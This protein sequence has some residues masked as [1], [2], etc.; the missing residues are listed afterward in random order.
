[1]TLIDLGD[2]Y[3]RKFVYSDIKGLYETMQDVNTARHVSNR[4]QWSYK[5]VESFIKWNIEHEDDYYYAIVRKSDNAFIGYV[6][7]KIYNYKDDNILT[8]KNVLTIVIKEKK[9]GYGKRVVNAYITYCNDNNI[10]LYASV[11]EDNTP[12]N[13]L[14]ISLG[15]HPQAKLRVDGIT[16]NI[17]FLYQQ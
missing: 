14:F 6:G 13:M 1:M 9:K 2:I 5:R 8:G 16:S 11:D 17:Y 7:H 15:Y 4:K 10:S 3:I 12:S